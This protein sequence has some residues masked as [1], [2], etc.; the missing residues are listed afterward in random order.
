[1][2]KYSL[3]FSPST[4]FP[5]TPSLPFLSSLYLSTLFPLPPFSVCPLSFFL[6]FFSFCFLP[7][8]FYPYPFSWRADLILIFSS[9]YP[10]TLFGRPLGLIF[11]TLF[12][13]YPY[14]FLLLLTLHLTSFYPSSSILSSYSSYSVFLPWRAN[15]L[16]ILFFILFPFNPLLLTPFS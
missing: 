6:Y 15:L 7:S 5:Y 14:P 2:S 16:F 8:T 10:Y 9:S 12:T 11:F 13:A 3:A 1:M 4:P